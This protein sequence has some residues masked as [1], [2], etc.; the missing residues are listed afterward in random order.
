[1]SD[2]NGNR[3]LIDLSGPSVMKI[4]T[5][6]AGV[7]LKDPQD[8]VLAAARAE[9][10]KEEAKPRIIGPH[11]CHAVGCQTVVPPEQLMCRPHWFRVPL[12]VR[13]RVMLSYTPGQCQDTK[14]IK[15]SWVL[16]ARQAI[17][18]VLQLELPVLASRLRLPEGYDGAQ[19]NIER[20]GISTVAI[21]QEGKPLLVGSLATGEV[22][23]VPRPAPAAA[24]DDPGDAQPQEP[25]A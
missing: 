1:M 9:A 10:A 22:K 23:E 21:H 13:K 6:R 20:V 4:A 12:G 17:E 25:T 18:F 24:N 19:V 8:D 5:E 16:A 15:Q 2:V 11:A 7:S 3:P 14:R